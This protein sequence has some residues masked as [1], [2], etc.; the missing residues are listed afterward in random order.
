MSASSG[1]T[2]T[3]DSG[4]GGSEDDSHSNRGSGL[5][6]GVQTE[7]IFHQMCSQKTISITCVDRTTFSIRLQTEK[8]FASDVQTEILLGQI[9]KNKRI[10][11]MSSLQRCNASPRTDILH[12]LLHAKLGVKI[13]PQG[14]QL[15]REGKSLSW[16]QRGELELADKSLVSEAIKRCPDPAGVVLLLEPQ[17]QTSSKGFWVHQYENKTLL[18]EFPMLPW[19]NT[20]MPAL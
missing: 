8:P 3:S 17:L 6:A 2:G 5:E 1:E 4:R 20:T 15:Q 18:F 10:R 13:H 16:G 9:S 11:K 12:Q 7:N 19:E 14:Q